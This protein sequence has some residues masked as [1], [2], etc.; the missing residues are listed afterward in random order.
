MKLDVHKLAVEK[1]SCEEGVSIFLGS[2][3]SKVGGEN[4]KEIKFWKYSWENYTILQSN[5]L[6]GC[7]CIIAMTNSNVLYFLP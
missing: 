5:M 2:D 6:T 3:V 4:L 1:V 7:G